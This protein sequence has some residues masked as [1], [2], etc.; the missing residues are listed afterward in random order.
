MWTNPL[1]PVAIKSYY[2]PSAV[3][4]WLHWRRSN[5]IGLTVKKGE[6]VQSLSKLSLEGPEVENH[7]HTAQPKPVFSGGIFFPPWTHNKRPLRSSWL[8]TE[9][10]HIQEVEKKRR[11]TM[12]DDAW[13][14]LAA[15]Y[16][17]ETQQDVIFKTLLCGGSRNKGGSPPSPPAAPSSKTAR[18]PFFFFFSIL[19]LPLTVRVHVLSFAEMTGSCRMCFCVV[20]ASII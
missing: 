7:H 3:S 5:L 17:R 13:C 6:F 4:N 12:K 8:R 14:L 15:G 18:G 19:L 10:A 9:A 1:Y 2:H 11:A 20:L 16:V